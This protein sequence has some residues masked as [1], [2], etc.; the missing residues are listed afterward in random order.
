MAVLVSKANGNWSSSSTWG[1]IETTSGLWN[2]LIASQESSNTNIQNY[3][4][5]TVSG[6]VTASGIVVDAVLVKFAYVT[7]TSPL[8]GTV[9]VNIKTGGTVV[10]TTSVAASTLEAILPNGTGNTS[11]KSWIAFELPSSYTFTA[12][13]HQVELIYTGF[14]SGQNIYVVTR[15]S[16]SGPTVCLRTTTTATPAATDQIVVCG[17]ITSAGAY[18]TRT[19][20]I[21]TA[22]VT[23]GP[24][25][26]GAASLDISIGGIL[27]HACAASTAYT[28]TSNGSI[29]VNESGSL[30]FGTSAAPLPSSSTLTV[31]IPCSSA[32]QFGF[33]RRGGTVTFYGASK[34][35]KTF[36][37]ANASAGATSLTTA[38]T[39]NWLSADTIIV[40]TTS[41]TSTES[42]FKTL[43]GAATGTTVPVAALTYAHTGSASTNVPKAEIGNMTRNIVLTGTSSA[44]GYRFDIAGTSTSAASQL[45]EFSNTEIKNFSTVSIVSTTADLKFSGSTINNPSQ[46]FSFN[47]LRSLQILSS[48]I[49]CGS[50]SISANTVP[51]VTISGSLFVFQTTSTSYG[52][53]ISQGVVSANISDSQ[54]VGGAGLQIYGGGTATGEEVV[55]V[56]NIIAHGGTGSQ[57]GVSIGT[58]NLYYSEAPQSTVV[59]SYIYSHGY[60][61]YV[62]GPSALISMCLIEGND[63]NVR[64]DKG[65]D[66]LFSSCVIRSLAGFTSQYGVS[67]ASS[68][69]YNDRITFDNVIFGDATNKHTQY[70]VS[71]SNLAGKWAFRNCSLTADASK[72]PILLATALNR[73]TSV[74]FQKYNNISNDNRVYLNNGRIEQDFAYNYLG[75]GQGSRLYPSNLYYPLATPAKTVAVPAW[76]KARISV[77]ARKGAAADASAKVFTS[78]GTTTITSANHGFKYGDYVKYTTTGG[79]SGLTNDSFYFVQTVTTNTFSL[80]STLTGTSITVG[81]GTGVNSLTL[82]TLY[83]GTELSL[84]VR[85]NYYAGITADTTLATTTAASAGAWEQL[86]GLTAMVTED[87]LLEFY[88][89]CKSTSTASSSGYITLDGWSVEIV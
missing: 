70:D 88:A 56:N 73:G 72:T 13:T 49:V 26:S 63:T 36:L 31:S 53:Q 18:A 83:G 33:Y 46:F 1:T 14:A 52:C 11:S 87:S 58:T 4:G 37:A 27:T 42:E 23:I 81:T 10:A 16:P 77:Y 5:G 41:R 57:P 85:R 55:S 35:N 39:T 54:F 89:S 3:S 61:V 28:F 21:D 7:G 82:Q 50:Y 75:A 84:M 2:Q 8:T 47:T 24:T 29:Y 59:N 32:N 48:V 12:A 66:V 71:L 79:A 30:S 6:S 43:S 34:V 62:N 74:S 76:K 60:G 80:S 69:G 20:T 25:V 9:T 19:V 17:A 51:T 45:V 38:D 78:N 65:T 68:G 44:L 22:A 15:S 40:A 64:I 86:T 67:G